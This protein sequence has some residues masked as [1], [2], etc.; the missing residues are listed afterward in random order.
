MKF[1]FI[2]QDPKQFF[3][4]IRL[5]YTNIVY[6]ACFVLRKKRMYVFNVVTVVCLTLKVM[7]L[8]KKSE[9]LVDRTSSSRSP[10]RGQCVL[11]R[12]RGE[13][14]RRDGRRNVLYIPSVCA[15]RW[16]KVL[17]RG[18][19]G[20]CL[21]TYTVWKSL[22]RVRCEVQRHST[23]W[24]RELASP[25]PVSPGPRVAWQ[26]TLGKGIQQGECCVAVFVC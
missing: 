13:C 18:L 10:S 3:P 1:P 17:P 7:S 14:D 4:H 24:Q 23:V 5:T 8:L 22:C 15:L 26:G 25:S 12:W 20:S 9:P 2:P 11:C 19:E 6:I 16:I 21:S